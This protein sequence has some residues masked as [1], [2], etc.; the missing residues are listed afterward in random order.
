[1]NSVVGD[2]IRS[3]SSQLSLGKMPTLNY[4]RKLELGA[5]ANEYTTARFSVLV[6]G[7]IVDQVLAT[8]MDHTEQEWTKLTDIDLSCFADQRVTLTFELAPNSNLYHKVF[9]KA[10][11]DCINIKETAASEAA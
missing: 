11:L 4:A 7:V 5:A 10:W 3:V 9:A 6:N 1:M 8:G 2:Q